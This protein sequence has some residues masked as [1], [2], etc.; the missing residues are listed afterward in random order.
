MKINIS[1]EATPEE[2]RQT[3][4]LPN[5]TEVQQTFLTKVAESMKDG[6]IDPGAMANLLGPS[7]SVGQQFMDAMVRSMDTMMAPDASRKKDA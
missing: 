5:L 1:I 2:F 4:G 3:L 6:S 7:F